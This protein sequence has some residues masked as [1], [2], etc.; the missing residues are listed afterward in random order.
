M[1]IG[2]SAGFRWTGHPFIDFGVATLCAWCEVEE[3][4]KLTDEKLKNFVQVAE[5]AYFSKPDLAKSVEIA[6][7]RN[8]YFQPTYSPEKIL[9]L[10]RQSL[11]AYGRPPNPD[12]PNCPF[13]KTSAVE[14]LSRDRFPMLMGRGQINFYAGGASGLPLSGQAITAIQVIMFGALRSQGK[15]M[16]LECDDPNLRQAVLQKWV[17]DIQ[18]YILMSQ[19][20]GTGSELTSAKTVLLN[21]LQDI[22][23]KRISIKRGGQVARYYG[24]ATLYLFSNSGQ[25]PGLEILALPAPILSFVQTAQ[26]DFMMGWGELRKRGWIF[27]K[28]KKGEAALPED[29]EPQ[30]EQRYSVNNRFFNLLFSLPQETQFFVRGYL[31]A[32]QK[33]LVEKV[34]DWSDKMKS[35]GTE[36]IRQ[37]WG[38]TELFLEEVLGVQRERI[39]NIKNLAAVLAKIVDHNPPRYK[40]ILQTKRSW[41]EIRRLLM[42][43]N[44]RETEKL[45]E[46]EPFLKFDDFLSVFEIAE[47]TEYVDWSLAWDLVLIR[48]LEVLHTEYDFYNKHKDV[49]PPVVEEAE[50]S[51]EAATVNA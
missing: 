3:P 5:K 22:E 33:I 28:P 6:G 29:Y 41:G 36:K 13:F 31:W 49:I 44:R 50:E 7:G 38:I 8:Y 35:P 32:S 51:Q 10:V 1:E 42:L 48:L 14:V 46:P 47:D 26:V 17:E 37:L 30:A 40:Q 23:E 27:P 21:T 4:E 15:L 16:V 20:S 19:Q 25:G 11:L 34:P 12:L 18:R 45:T 9:E 43:L 2:E 24:G 39:E